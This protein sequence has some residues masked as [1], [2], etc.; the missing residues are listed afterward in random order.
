MSHLLDINLL[1][2]CGW[3]GHTDHVRANR[4]LGSLTAFATAPL[5]QMGFLRI[6]LSP[7]YGATFA[8]AQ[9]ALGSLLNPGR[10]DS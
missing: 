9:A 1:L 5:T 4:W 10:I 7:G 8:D 6:S 2:A 3:S